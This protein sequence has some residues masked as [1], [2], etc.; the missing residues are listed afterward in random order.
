M[1]LITR[2][3]ESPTSPETAWSLPGAPEAFEGGRRALRAG[4]LGPATSIFRA[5]AS[6]ESREDVWLSLA[7][8]ELAL[9]RVAQCRVILAEI[10]WSI[11]R[12]V[13][14][15]EC[16]LTCGETIRA[17]CLW[18][19]LSASVP[20]DPRVRFLEGQM[21]AH[22]GQSQEAEVVF[23]S[24]AGDPDVGARACA[25]AVFCAV[26]RG[27]FEGAR[28]LLG[29]LR[30]DDAACEG[31]R[32]CIATQAGLDWTPSER[33]EPATCRSWADRWT[34]WWIRGGR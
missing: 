24:L 25:W 20:Q 13:L 27:D 3:V 8:T 14:E 16:A 10:P 7:E 32:E 22:S 12:A 29:K 34:G 31:L 9:G 11:Q 6:R 18:G 26:R 2:K 4:F 21:M 23:L 28:T 33:V 30:D 5:L 15:A 17:L 19:E 1:D